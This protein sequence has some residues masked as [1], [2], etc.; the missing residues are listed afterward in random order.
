MRR[1]LPTRFSQ[2]WVKRLLWTQHHWAEVLRVR[3]VWPGGR[4]G[5]TM[6]STCLKWRS[7]SSPRLYL[8]PESPWNKLI[9][10]SSVVPRRP[11]RLRDRWWWWWRWSIQ[12]PVKLITSAPFARKIYHLWELTV[13][14]NLPILPPPQFLFSPRCKWTVLYLMSATIFFTDLHRDC[15]HPLLHCLL[16]CHLWEVSSDHV[17][18]LLS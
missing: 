17:L 10:K 1:S 3:R 5:S 7:V 8:V 11:S 13:T 18:V 6:N 12:T 16:L 2:W 4:K 15:N 9:V 14:V